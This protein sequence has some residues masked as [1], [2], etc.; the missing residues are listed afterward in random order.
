MVSLLVI[1]LRRSLSKSSDD[2]D[3]FDTSPLS[4]IDEKR[5]KS[6]NVDFSKRISSTFSFGQICL[7]SERK[8]LFNGSIDDSFSFGW[9]KFDRIVRFVDGSVT[10]WS[11]QWKKFS[12]KDFFSVIFHFVMIKPEFRGRIMSNDGRRYDLSNE[13]LFN[14]FDVVVRLEKKRKTKIWQWKIRWK[15]IELVRPNCSLKSLM[16]RRTKRN[17]TNVSERKERRR[18]RASH[19]KHRLTFSKGKEK[20][21]FFVLIKQFLFTWNFFIFDG[22]T[23][24]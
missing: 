17:A 2:E 21:F 16:N 12:S 23:S 14:S 9:I 11:F 18:A 22:S 8:R 3:R 5:S 24:M 1:A 10:T 19:Q 15:Q 6:E 4:L 13:H 7:L 20:T